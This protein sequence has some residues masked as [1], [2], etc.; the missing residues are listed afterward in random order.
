MEQELYIPIKGKLT[1]LAKSPDGDSVRFIPEDM[2]ALR[3]LKYGRRLRP[4][5]DHSVQ[6]RLDGIDAPETHYAGR[7]Q[8]LG[9][10]ARDIF[11][12]TLG[13]DKVRFSARGAVSA[14]EPEKL[15]ATILAK[16]V[17]M[18]GRPVAYLFVGKHPEFKAAKKITLGSDLLERSLN[19]KMIQNGFAYP[20]LY[21]STPLAHRELFTTL[22]A[23]AKAEELGVW[24]A[25][26]TARFTLNNQDSIGPKGQL[27]FPKVFRR[28]TDYLNA[29]SKGNKDTFLE[30][31]TVA[32][33]DDMSEDDALFV[34]T[35]QTS[36]SEVIR[37]KGKTIRFT[38]D[39]MDIVFIEK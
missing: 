16:M 1:L 35:E 2:T 12:E 15:P 20:L 4:S 21:T 13:F 11:L 28:C 32:L 7:A 36:L 22:G 38:A 8:P 14:S 24:K 19:A 26:K 30:W 34:G 29:K 31:L 23:I 39:L 27:I 25:D 5:K 33:D 18:H 17:E 6:L 10:E 37:M 3:K 9:E